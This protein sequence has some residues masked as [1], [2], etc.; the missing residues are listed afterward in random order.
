M[1]IVYYRPT[2]AYAYAQLYVVG[3][4]TLDLELEVWPVTNITEEWSNEHDHKIKMVNAEPHCCK[5][6]LVR[7]WCVMS[8]D[9]LYKLI[10]SALFYGRTIL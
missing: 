3:S 6:V 2:Y 5:L 8:L 9:V 1:Y 4:R 10:Y 7:T